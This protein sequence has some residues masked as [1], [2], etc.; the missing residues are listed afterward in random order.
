LEFHAQSL[1]ESATWWAERS[2]RLKGRAT[3]A[4]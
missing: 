1:A 4:L 2:E 3:A